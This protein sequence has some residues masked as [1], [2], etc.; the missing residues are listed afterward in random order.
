MKA[1]LLVAL[2]A[3]VP[4]AHAAL[5]DDLD[6]TETYYARAAVGDIPTTSDVEPEGQL[7]VVEYLRFDH[8]T[9]AESGTSQIAFGGGQDALA[10]TCGAFS[11]QDGQVL[12]H[13][14]TEAGS[15]VLA[16]VR[17]VPQAQGYSL[18]LLLF[19][20]GVAADAEINIYAPSG[21][22]VTAPL[23]GATLACTD[24]PCT[25]HSFA[26]PLPSDFWAVMHPSLAPVPTQTI[27]TTEPAGF[28]Y[29][30]LILGLAAGALIWFWLVQKGFVQARTRKQVVAKAVH[31]EV[32]ASESKEMLAARKRVLMA[33]LKDLEMAKMKKEIDDATYDQLKAELKKEAVTAMRAMESQQ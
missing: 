17:S 14:T 19:G 20:A 1:L 23:G 2:L 8:P 24:A 21:F 12:V 32:A 18:P 5:Q 11:V 3:L 7:N 4:G 30:E 9:D 16:V 29:L 22:D 6:F 15:Y 13:D 28:G 25:I 10:C 31:E 33:G 27:T 26:S